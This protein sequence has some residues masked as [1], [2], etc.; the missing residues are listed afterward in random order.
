MWSYRALDS[1]WWKARDGLSLPLARLYCKYFGGSLDLVPMEGFGTDCYVS[2]NRLAHKNSEHIIPVDS[3]EEDPNRVGV[4]CSTRRRDEAEATRREKSHQRR[5][6]ESGIVRVRVSIIM[7]RRL[8][9]YHNHD[10]RAI[11]LALATLYLTRIVSH[12]LLAASLT[13]HRPPHNAYSHSFE[14]IHTAGDASFV[15]LASSAP[16]T[17]PLERWRK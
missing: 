3:N 2:F 7:V 8:P 10:S 16:S 13:H 17:A 5:L 12:L 6:R 14:A 4:G 15:A 1:K 9:P 11:V